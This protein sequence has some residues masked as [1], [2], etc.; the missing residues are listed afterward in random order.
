MSKSDS[1][2]AGF[3]EKNRQ[4]SLENTAKMPNSF[5][6]LFG[7]KELEESEKNRLE[8]LLLPDIHEGEQE[9][10]QSDF[11][12]LVSTAAEVRAIQKQGILLLGERIHKAREIL[13]AYS[14]AK[15]LLSKWMQF[16]FP[17]LKT[18]YNALGFYELYR[19]LPSQELKDKYQKMPAKAGYI[20]ASREGD[21]TKKCAFIENHSDQL[22][23]ALIEEIQHV[24]PLEAEDKR[25]KK[26]S[27]AH[28]IAEIKHLL[29]RLNHVRSHLT[30]SEKKELLEI[31]DDIYQHFRT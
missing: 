16:S 30:L 13:L 25:V 10:F 11:A 24:F 26:V 29:N 14:G 3:L 1:L 7:I 31:A 28:V 27:G 6:G 20:L 9:Q 18:A 5:Q 4:K 8:A 19:A 23:K 22:A 21:I 17:S 2:V 12:Q 15:S